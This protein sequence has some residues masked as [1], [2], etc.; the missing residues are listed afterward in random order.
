[1]VIPSSRC[2]EILRRSEPQWLLVGVGLLCR[3]NRRTFS[4]FYCGWL[5]LLDIA[6]V[7]ARPKPL[8][9]SAGERLRTVK[10]EEA[11]LESHRSLRRPRRLCREWEIIWQVF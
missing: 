4:Q 11:R 10:N 5:R 9:E 6:R 1:M 8:P 7:Q 2:L 3:P